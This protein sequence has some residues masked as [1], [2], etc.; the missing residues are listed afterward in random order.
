M[1]NSHAN[2]VI[3]FGNKRIALSDFAIRYIAAGAPGRGP[4]QSVAPHKLVEFGYWGVQLTVWLFWL[5]LVIFVILA[6]LVILV[7]LVNLVN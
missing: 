1:A 3:R 7:I 4:R 2:F 6:I 5:F